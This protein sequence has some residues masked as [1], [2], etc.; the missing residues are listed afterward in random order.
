MEITAATTN[1]G[2]PYFLF[3]DRNETL[4]SIQ[5]SSLAFEQAIWF[6][7]EDPDPKSMIPYGQPGAHPWTPYP[8]PDHVHIKTRMH[9]TQEEVREIL[10]ILQYFAEN[11]ELPSVEEGVAVQ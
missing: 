9:L 6:G 8:L 4:C 5:K 3:K 2:F 11:G 10:P 1:R 7:V